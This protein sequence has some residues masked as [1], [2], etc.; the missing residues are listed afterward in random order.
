MKPDM[1][2]RAAF[3]PGE[4]WRCCDGCGEVL[5]FPGRA[6]AQH[7]P[8][9]ARTKARPR[10]TATDADAARVRRCAWQHA[11]SDRLRPRSITR[12]GGYSRAAHPRGDVLR[13][14][15]RVLDTTLRRRG[16]DTTVVL[17][18]HT[19][20]S[21][22]ADLHRERPGAA[23]GGLACPI[24][25]PRPTRPTRPSRQG[26]RAHHTDDRSAPP[27]ARV[28]PDGN[29]GTLATANPCCLSA[30]VWAVFVSAPRRLPRAFLPARPCSARTRAAT[31]PCPRACANMP[32]HARARRRVGGRLALRG[33]GAAAHLRTPLAAPPLA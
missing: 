6:L 10:V 24:A 12:A 25:T 23:E 19:H 18:P 15:T 16:R 8:S 22:H 30:S 7:D 4:R 11:R 9:G 28:R 3:R 17:P 31:A 14:H 33:R 5:E 27:A 1:C 21:P 29:R 32:R 13:T 26:A 20:G 2:S